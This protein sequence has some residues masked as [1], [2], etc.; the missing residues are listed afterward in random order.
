MGRNRKG[1]ERDGI[2]WGG[3][4]DQIA[5]EDLKIRSDRIGKD[6]IGPIGSDYRVIGPVDRVGGLDRIDRVG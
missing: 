1:I 3:M 2:E 4:D 5:L 6:R